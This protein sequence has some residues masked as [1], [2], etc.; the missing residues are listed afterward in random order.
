MSAFFRFRSGCRWSPGCILAAAGLLGG[1][2][3]YHAQPLE[4]EAVN[5]A[6]Q[7]APIESIRI[8][9][10]KLQHPL[11]PPILIDGRDGYSPDEIAVMV[12]VSSPE[13]RALRDQ[14]GVA[15]AQ[16]VQAGIL[17]NP[18]LAYALDN[19]HG[20]NSDPTLVSATSLGL[21]WDATSLLAHR[22]Q[23]A[24]ARAAA[25]SVDLSVAWQE[26]QAA[27]EARLRAFRI[28]SLE[29]RLPLAREIETDLAD[30]L[31]LDEKAL[32]LG[33]QTAPD[34]TAAADAWRQAKNARFDLETDLASQRAALRLSLGLPP[35]APLPLKAAPEFPVFPPE[36]AASLLQGLED[37]RLDLMALRAGYASQ[38]ATLRAAVKAQFPK[39]NLGINRANDTTP[40]HTRGWGIT[41]DLPIFDRNQGQIAIGR[42]TRQQLFDEYVARVA[43]ARSQVGEI[44]EELA[45]A[46]AQWRDAEA[47][48]PPLQRLAESL[49]TAM[50]T[51]N[52]DLASDRDARGAL[53]A[54]RIEEAQLQ[55]QVLELGVALEIATGRPLLNRT[56]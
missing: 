54:R 14:Q 24:A 52:A 39:I 29:R 30:G 36:T 53:A 28:L 51:R 56:H 25:K 31:A 7:P 37:R 17:P 32:G 45:V 34:L 42:T 55:Q 2:S 10:A 8:A 44:L 43:E 47:S 49:D 13:L 11:L 4:P 23:V 6:L 26:W 5:A 15:E 40:V 50:Q 48:L 12:V 19:P 20:R 3:T 41:A 21:S 35:E 46:R 18:Q 16:V 38:D 1:C 9:A 27:Q 22:D 33:Y